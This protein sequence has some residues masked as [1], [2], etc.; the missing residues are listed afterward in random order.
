MYLWWSFTNQ[1]LNTNWAITSQ[2]HGTAPFVQQSGS[3]LDSL[4]FLWEFMCFYHRVNVRIG[5]EDLQAPIPWVK[6]KVH[7]RTGLEGPEREY[8]FSST[9]SLT[10]MLDGV[11]GQRHASAALPPG[12]TQYPLYRRLSGPQGPS[13][14]VRKISP[15]PGFDPRTVQHVA[16]PY[17]DW[18]IP[19]HP[20][21]WVP[22]ES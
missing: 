11:V 5:T 10:S 9:L 8:R 4:W 15:S 2:T 6:G 7:P 1:H 18:N 21:I 22:G 20:I 16:S 12:K 17:T 19:A 13:G 14:R 3:W